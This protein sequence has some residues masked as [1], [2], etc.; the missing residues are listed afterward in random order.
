MDSNHKKAVAP[1]VLV[2]ATR[3]EDQQHPTFSHP[4]P[5]LSYENNTNTTT[6]SA[7]PS[8]YHDSSSDVV[9][10]TIGVSLLWLVFLTAA[11]MFRYKALQ[12]EQRADEERRVRARH[13]PQGSRRRKQFVA[14]DPDKRRVLIASWIVTRV[15]GY[16]ILV[17][18]LVLIL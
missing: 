14:V 10:A 11:C 16:T 12:D 2:I 3:D 6:E 7:L 18:Y 8:E 17:Y 4:R 1:H 5:V 9:F 15:R 13:R